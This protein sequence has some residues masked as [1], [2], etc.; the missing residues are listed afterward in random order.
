LLSG[1]AFVND[2][3]EEIEFTNDSILIATTDWLPDRY[4]LKK[5]NLSLSFSDKHPQSEYFKNFK[6]N[7]FS[8]D[9]ILLSYVWTGHPAT[10]TTEFIN[11]EKL[12]TPIDDFD[13]LR[14]YA[15]GTNQ[16]Q[17]L[18]IK[19]DKSVQQTITIGNN[20]D[21]NAHSYKKLILTDK[22]YQKFLEMLSKGLIFK[23]PRQ[24]P[25]T[26]S[27]E[28][29]IDISIYTNRQ[30]IISNGGTLSGVH[31][32]LMSYLLNIK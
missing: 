2:K 24:R 6:V 30:T 31:Q 12:I 4:K 27:D 1:K 23:L 29:K 13:S 10:Q 22:Q 8:D 9:K 18:V 26:A 5:Q 19:N 7:N 17:I 11:L 20:F 25:F 15:R 32:K 16:Y 3:L 21:R 14:I 28:T